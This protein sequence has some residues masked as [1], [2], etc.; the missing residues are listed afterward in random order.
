MD[1]DAFAAEHGPEWHRLRTLLGRPRRKLSAAE[2]DELVTLY[3]RAATHLSI[4]QSRSP[5]PDLTTMLTRLVLTARAAVTPS[6]GFRW[7]VVGRFFTTAFPLEVYR[8]GRWCL[9]TGLGFVALSTLLILIVAG[10]PEVP[11]RFLTQE[12]ITAL[13]ERDF[14]DYYRSAPAQN[15]GFAVWTNNAWVSAICLASGVIV[16]PVLY[17]L[18]VNAVNLGLV[19]GVMVGND[20]TDLFLGL[21]L[22]HGMLELTC[23]FVAAGV[24][25]RIG[26]SW[27]APGPLRSR[28]QAV[29]AAGRSG[30]VV[31][32][33]LVPV[34]LVSGIV[35]AFV[36]PSVLPPVVKLTIGAVAWLAFLGYVAVVGGRARRLGESADVDAPDREAVAPTV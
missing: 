24:G 30:L 3:R 5:D 17:V 15:F 34:L 10:D 36:T 27:I 21:L 22:V 1:V 20:R 4:V 26:W 28:G 33:G 14:E 8:A 2:V 25:L 6:P 12:E 9:G 11:L 23:V 35:E 16:L 31:A 32:L 13:V 29:A 18:W 7:A 19:G